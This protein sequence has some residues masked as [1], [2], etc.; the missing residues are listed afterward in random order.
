MDKLADY[1]VE[2]LSFEDLQRTDG[3]CWVCSIWGPPRIDDPPCPG[4]GG[5]G[6]LLAN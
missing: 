2:T 5:S 1:Q 4:A 3:G 6:A